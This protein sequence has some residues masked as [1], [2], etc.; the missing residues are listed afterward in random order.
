VRTLI[1]NG[2]VATG[3]R[4]ESVDLLIED[5]RIAA[6]G[7]FPDLLPDREI[8]ATGLFVLPGFMD[9]HTHIADRIGRY[10]LADGYSSGTEVAVR[11]GITTVC[12]FVTQGPGESLPGALRRAQDKAAGACH[13]DLLWHLTPTGYEPADLADQ[14]ALAEAGFR[15]WKF[16]TTYR[17]A[18]LYCDLQRLEDNFRRLGPLG[19]RILM[20]CEDDGCLCGVD[21]DSL[22]LTRASSHPRLRPSAAEARS[23][24]D[25]VAL[26]GKFSVPLHVVHVSTVEAAERLMEARIRADVTC[27]TCPQYLWLDEGWL[28]RQDGHRWLC[29]PPL[30]D[31]RET[32]RALARGGAFDILATDHCAFHAADKDDWDRR[33]IRAVA[34]GVAGLGALPHLAWKLWA[35]DPPR[36]ALELAHRLSLNPARRAGVEGRKGDL[37][38][39]LD[40]DVVLLDPAGPEQPVCSSLSDSFETYPGFTST[41]TLREVLLRGQTVA[42][43]GQLAAEGAFRGRPLQRSL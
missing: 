11:N 6:L 15:T 25:L 3:G 2:R 32:F 20:H 16:Y 35:E 29:S 42:R 17:A 19:A 9:F 18:G 1:R 24:E 10:E 39:G 40:A 30:R 41:L 36:A 38:P 26:A 37:R 8:D 33:D 23:V 28:A 7:Q 27:E 31:R 22:D 43:D 5:S 34:N 14:R 12:T 21:P 13:A 4:L